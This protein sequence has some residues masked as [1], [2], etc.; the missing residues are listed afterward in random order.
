MVPFQE[1]ILFDEFKTLRFVKKLKT[2]TIDS[3]YY[4]FNF[5]LKITIS[6]H[7]Y[8][9]L[10]SDN[11]IKWNVKYFPATSSKYFQHSLCLTLS[12]SSWLKKIVVSADAICLSV[13]TNGKTDWNF[14]LYI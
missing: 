4:L 8:S 6:G 12:L 11:G 5:N 3:L 14:F 13:S 1:V 10:C 2:K 7:E 9:E